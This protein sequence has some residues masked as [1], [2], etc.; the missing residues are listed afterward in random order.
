M[1]RTILLVDE[2]DWVTTCERLLQPLG[3]VCLST[4]TGPDAIALIDREDPGL[5]VTELRV[6][7]ADGLAVARHARVRVPPIPVIVITAYDS[8]GARRAAS[9]AGVAAYLA[10]PFA[11]A[12]VL[13]AVGCALAEQPSGPRDALAP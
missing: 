4:S 3:H 10:K 6:P 12:A 9:E 8:A 1:V 2:P 5:V 11:N 7:G 13:D